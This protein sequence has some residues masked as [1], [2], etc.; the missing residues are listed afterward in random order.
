[1][2]IMPW[3]YAHFV[4]K[5]PNIR[6]GLRT[7]MWLESP[8]IYQ[9]WIITVHLRRNKKFRVIQSPSGRSVFLEC[10]YWVTR[11]EH[12][13]RLAVRALWHFWVQPIHWS[14]P[15]T[16]ARATKI[17]VLLINS[18]NKETRSHLKLLSGEILERLIVTWN[19]C[20]CISHV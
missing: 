2:R 16:L 5:S 7:R 6:V 9:S 18:V 8:H 14:Q 19:R 15:I 10:I 13:E 1:M 4:A 17:H 11:V 12:V 20:M 3:N